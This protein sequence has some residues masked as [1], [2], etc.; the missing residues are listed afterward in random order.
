M[1]KFDLGWKDDAV[2]KGVC[3]SCRGPVPCRVQF[4]VPEWEFTPV[5]QVPTYLTLSFVRNFVRNRHAC[6]TYTHIQ[7]KYSYI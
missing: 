5:T 7:A 1:Q 3:Y 4:P 2:V 6:G